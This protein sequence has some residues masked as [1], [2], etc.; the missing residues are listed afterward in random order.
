MTVAFICYYKIVFFH[1]IE[2]L[3]FSCRE[4]YVNFK[5]DLSLKS[6]KLDYSNLK[7]PQC[8]ILQHREKWSKKR[9]L[10]RHKNKNVKFPP[11]ALV[12]RL[13]H[14]SCM[15]SVM[16]S[17][18]AFGSV[19]DKA[20]HDKVSVQSRKLERLLLLRLCELRP[21]SPLVHLSSLGSSEFRSWF[22]ACG[23]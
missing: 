21:P 12:L 19:P 10:L 15:F 2:N 5:C 18:H 9:R 3:F 23:Q 13:A 17:F 20:E 22:I 8:N 4:C 11:P 6:P 7:S 14:E 1:L 16:V